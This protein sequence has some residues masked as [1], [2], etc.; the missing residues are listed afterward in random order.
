M[1]KYLQDSHKN[2]GST[3][4]IVVICMSFLGILATVVLSTAF[5]NYQMKTIDRYAKA[6]FYTAE[7]AIDELKA[8]FE[9]EMSEL[10][11]QAYFKIMVT[12][13]DY[14]IGEKNLEFKKEFLKRF[15][16]KYGEMDSYTLTPVEGTIRGSDFYLY[17][18]ISTYLVEKENR[19]VAE[20]VPST[21]AN[22][23]EWSLDTTNLKEQYISLKNVEVSYVESNTYKTQIKTDFK[24]TIPNIEFEAI[25][26]IPPFA[27]YAI[28]GDKKVIVDSIG[29]IVD[30]NIYAGYDGIVAKN[31]IFKLVSDVVITRGE[32]RA[33]NGGEMVINA[34]KDADE[35]G[36][37]WADDLV[38]MTSA[39]GDMDLTGD[40][41]IRDDL[42][43]NGNNS[44]VSLTGNYFG[45]G[46]GYESKD[47]VES[48]V[49]HDHK[50]SSSMI[51]NRKN[52][53]LDLH[54]LGNLFVAGRAFITA[55]VETGNLELSNNVL[56]GEAIATKADQV[57]YWIPGGAI[58]VRVLEDGTKLP[59][60]GANPISRE[61]YDMITAEGSSYLEV[62]MSYQILGEGETQGK[63]LSH[64]AVGFKKIFDVVD[65][66]EWVYY[67]LEFENEMKANEYVQACINNDS[68]FNRL[69]Q[70]LIE[71]NSVIIKPDMFLNSEYG[72]K[73]FA[74]N[75][76]MFQKNA[77][78]QA[79]NV[80]VVSN[81][82]NGSLPKQF[83]T[84]SDELLKEYTALSQKLVRTLAPYEGK[85]YDKE[86]TFHALIIGADGEENVGFKKLCS[87]TR[88]VITDE[89][90]GGKVILVDNGPA[91]NYENRYIVAEDNE[92]TDKPCIII[93]T[94]DVEV[95]KNVNGLI[96]SAGTVT[97]KNEATI[98]AKP[99]EVFELVC[100][101]DAK[102]VFRDFSE[103]AN[104]TDEERYDTVP[105]ESL[106]QVEN[107]RR[108]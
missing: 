53:T 12:Y 66:K 63:P 49:E 64:Y 5:T 74:G 93:A 84:E 25:G 32:V 39:G 37:I 35:W 8:G 96:L 98:T 108:N 82:V 41:Y 67:Y 54:N 14:S 89:D 17:D 94:G 50:K 86:S 45:Y 70:S 15:L 10:I 65:S 42:T 4:L 21:T 105:I 76:V 30:G 47:K 7:M 57:M 26:D 28:I 99:Y 97:L 77:E 58:G 95:S 69:Y 79:T 22:I 51:I 55:D 61:Y 71:Y 40:F 31:S 85:T 88:K 78:T 38:T 100:N 16:E 90:S 60:S 52:C 19:G 68:Y 101:T 107:W 46:Y 23:M 91:G 43:L 9:E 20:V 62:D 104:Y 11:G 73:T 3:I 83:M 103:F 27:E 72:R 48:G 24:F 87:G 44:V 59:G 18:D 33:E 80:E 102:Y 56:T 75:I 29:A 34:G 81:S 1:A 2:S 106:I 36:E 92:V 6:N 13:S